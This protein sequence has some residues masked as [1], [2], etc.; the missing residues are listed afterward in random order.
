MKYLFF[1]SKE[2]ILLAK[3]EVTVL[4]DAY[5]VNYSCFLDENLLI[6]DFVKINS[7]LDIINSIG[8]RLSYTKAIY[9]Y[10][11]FFSKD[12]IEYNN[13]DM[14]KNIIDFF[15][16]PE[17]VMEGAFDFDKY[18]RFKFRK[19]ELLPYYKKNFC[20][21]KTKISSDF[22]FG[23]TE[24][25]FSDI[26]FNRLKLE[27]SVNNREKNELIEVDLK[28]P[29]TSYE[30]FV[31]KDVSYLCVLIK[32]CEQDFNSRNSKYLPARLPISLKP[33]LAR[34]LVN[35]TG[36]KDGILYDPFCGIGGF[37]IE[38]GIMDLEIVGS[39]VDQEMLS[40]TKINLD[41]FGLK[42][43]KLFL[44]DALET[45]QISQGVVCD[46]PYGKNTKNIADLEIFC[47][48]FLNH[49]YDFCDV[50]VIGFPDF[51]ESA[52][53]ID[54]TFWSIDFSFDY[55]LHKSLSKKIFRLVKF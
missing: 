36:V 16:N 23:V 37:L 38:A 43:K 48:N 22:S 2:N 31:S 51:I 49:I 55:Y 47:L 3:K 35:L 32:N 1:L 33:K 39:D 53:I 42:A 27:L 8:K 5:E 4:L 13:P 14:I 26:I 46:V 25:E 52:K 7:E 17:E 18:L 21:R 12:G 10:L 45:K 50:L 44:Q 11:T 24:K 29:E 40:R 34:I 28:K 30:L 6:V 9:S 15:D 41:Y 20:F 54:K 19:I